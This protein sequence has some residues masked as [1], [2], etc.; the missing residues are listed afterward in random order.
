MTGGHQQ[1]W[2]LAL[3]H[4]PLASASKKGSN[5]T[6]D[7]PVARYLRSSLCHKV[8]YWLSGHSHHLEHRKLPGCRLETM[9]IGGGGGTLEEVN[10]KSREA[11]FIKL[12]YGFV[13]MDITEDKMISTFAFS[14]VG[15]G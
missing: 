6:G 4:Y 9:V 2:T 3:G 7:T 14:E 11:N 8:D 1:K 13:Q 12:D 5:Y 15:L 10:T